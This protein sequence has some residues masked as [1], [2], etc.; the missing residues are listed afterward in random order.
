VFGAHINFRSLRS[1]S[2]L[3]FFSDRKDNLYVQVT[4]LQA[5]SQLA[6]LDMQ[7]TMLLQL[8]SFSTAFNRVDEIHFLE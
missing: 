3:P 1:L 2:L 8:T 4:T 6:M 5:L 7:A